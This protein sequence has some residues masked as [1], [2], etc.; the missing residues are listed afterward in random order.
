MSRGRLPYFAL[1]LAAGASAFWL[2][3]VGAYWAFGGDWGAIITSLPFT[4]LL[5]VFCC[6]VLEVLAVGYGRPRFGLS[7]A[8]ILGIWATA[9]FWIM[10]AN[11]CMAGE[12]F[13]M[14]DAWS[15]VAFMTATFPAST[16][17]F[18]TYNGSLGALLFTTLA[19]PI[20]SAANWTFQPLAGRCCVC[21]Y[22]LRHI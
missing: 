14:V 4:F 20:F 21:R 13:H 10:F 19:L 12:G 18:S 1:G 11:T 6:F 2:P 9:P 22:A 15:S 16:L 8:M 5:P 7:A 17:M 3:V